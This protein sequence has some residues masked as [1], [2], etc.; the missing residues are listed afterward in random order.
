VAACVSVCGVCT[1]CRAILP[2]VPGG[3]QLEIWRMRI[4]CWI[5]KATNI[6]LEY[7]TL[8]TFPLQQNDKASM[9]RYTYVHCLSCLI[10]LSEGTSGLH[11]DGLLFWGWEVRGQRERIFRSE[12]VLQCFAVGIKHS[13]WR[14]E[15]NTCCGMRKVT[16]V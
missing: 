5:P 10:L 11:M 8:I 7:V 1:E 13:G 3:L 16:R 15:L 2:T 6:D 12:A 14:E 4:A 9:L